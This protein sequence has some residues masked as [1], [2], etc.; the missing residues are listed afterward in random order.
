MIVTTSCYDA[1]LA[2]IHQV[3]LWTNDSGTQ[4]RT[5]SRWSPFANV[6]AAS[7][8]LTVWTMLLHTVDQVRSFVLISRM[9]YIITCDARNFIRVFLCLFFNSVPVAV[10]VS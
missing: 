9:L 8:P 3:V 5:L 7:L 4:C 1:D 2:E 6:L 10:R